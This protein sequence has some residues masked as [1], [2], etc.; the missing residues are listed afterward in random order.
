MVGSDVDST[1]HDHYD[2]IVIGLGI[3]GSAAAYQLSKRG[4]RVL[5]LEQFT[6]AHDKGSSH[7]TTRML[8]KS[9]FEH[10][11]YVPL[12]LRSYEIWEELEQATGRKLVTKTGGFYI[13]APDEAYVQGSIDSARAYGIDH[14]VLDAPE[15]QRRFPQ[16]TARADQVAYY[17]PDMGVVKPEKCVLAQQQLA[18]RNGAEIHFGETVLG[19]EADGDRDRVHV[20]TD[21]G[22]YTAR[23]LIISA[24]AWAPR[25]LSDMELPLEI[26]RH[27]IFLFEPREGTLDDFHVGKFPLINVVA[28]DGIA[29]TSWPVYGTEQVVKA[30]FVHIDADPCTPETMTTQEVS[31]DELARIK[32]SLQ[33][34]VP[35]AAGRLVNTLSC[36]YTNAPDEHFVI[37]THPSHSNVVVAAGMAGHGFKF[38]PAIGEIL[39]DL[40]IDGETA[41]DIDLFSPSR[42]AEQAA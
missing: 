33:Q 17:E 37:S 42:F 11:A 22:R 35:N 23:R 30:T 34:Y 13:A 7:G 21:E 9:S 26:E 19:W 5:G 6:P 25:L 28:D 14:E 41:Y 40:A 20:R 8:R 2:V 1:P 32:R 31:P 4:Q 16:V 12:G 39:A 18:Q 24:G 27:W 3:M 38:A 29:F 36:M 15:L 10:P